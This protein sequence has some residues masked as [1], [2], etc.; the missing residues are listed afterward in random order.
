MDNADLDQQGGY[1]ESSGPA[2]GGQ[3]VDL[4]NYVPI[5]RFNGL[6]RK[7]QEALRELD[8]WKTKY[9]E[10]AAERDTLVSQHTLE[11]EKAE[12]AAATLS[13]Q[14]EQ[15]TGS[16]QELESRVTGMARDLQVRDLLMQPEYAPLQKLHAA[17]ALRI[18]GLEGEALTEYLNN[19]K[20]AVTEMG[21]EA[22]QNYAA[23]GSP[24]PPGGS[25]GK[26]KLSEEELYDRLMGMPTSDPNYESVRAEYYA[27][28]GMK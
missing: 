15:L 12:K 6:N 21:S 23:G 22:A 27:S 14:I 2:S 8:G 1:S 5:Q 20:T 16:N 9:G 3:S 19:L 28:I 7:L 24:P 11:L 17:N 4:S 10:I 13:Q 25:S 18:E 26:T